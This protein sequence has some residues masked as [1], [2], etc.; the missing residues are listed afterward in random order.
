MTRRSHRR[1]PE[2]A[3]RL[4]GHL[5]VL[6]QSGNLLVCNTR[7]FAVQQRLGHIQRNVVET[8]PSRT[9]LGTFGYAKPY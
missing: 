2:P 9:P 4:S 5:G 6:Q 7:R 3:T 1:L 8:L